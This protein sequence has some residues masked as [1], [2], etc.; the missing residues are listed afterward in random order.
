MDDDKKHPRIDWIIISTSLWLI[1]YT[2]LFPFD[3]FFNGIANQVDWRFPKPGLT[4]FVRNVVLFIPFGLGIAWLG[5]SKQLKFISLLA[6][7]LISGIGLSTLVEIG[8]LFV[9][10]RDPA[11]SDL[12]ANGLGALLGLFVFWPGRIKVQ[13]YASVLS[14]RFKAYL[15]LPILITIL[16]GYLIFAFLV[17]VLTPHDTKLTNWAT[18]FPLILGNEQTGDRAWEGAISRFVLLNRAIS[19][20]EIALI[21]GGEDIQAVVK[22]DW[23]AFYPLTNPSQLADQTGHLPDLVW[24]GTPPLNHQTRDTFLSSEHWLRTP[25]PVTSLAQ[26]VAD[27][28]QFT[29]G[30]V[31]APANLT[32]TGPA[33][34]ISISGDPF[35]RNLTL[36]QDGTD[37]IIRLRTPVTG[38]NGQLPELSIPNLFMDTTSH[39]LI[40]TYN[41]SKL[42]LYVDGLQY[43]HTFTLT[44][45]VTF[46]RYLLPVDIWRIR[47]NTNYLRF[48]QLFLF[49]GFLVPV[50]ILL[51]LMMKKFY[52]QR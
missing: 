15:S 49:S 30:V 33:R 36:G 5:L 18:D 7:V 44:A 26:H 22:D 52:E 38:Q 13:H 28:S 25:A 2:T 31:I 23:L 21:F 35:H 29:L 17:Y 20:E 43:A 41:E 42:R 40:I 3:F 10:E 4:D 19:E 51:N 39:H 27:T 14:T 50:A 47:I 24:Q 9:S 32:Q 34:I 48:Y 8:Q 45:Q 46:F 37:L 12:L 11:L 6:A 1:L 16:I